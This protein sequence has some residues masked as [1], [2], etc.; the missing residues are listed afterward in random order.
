[1]LKTPSI[2]PK[3]RQHVA[4]P[5]HQV[6]VVSRVASERNRNADSYP[7]DDY[8]LVFSFDSVGGKT[9]E[10]DNRGLV[11]A[12]AIAISRV[13]ISEPERSRLC[14]PTIPIQQDYTSNMKAY[15]L[16]TAF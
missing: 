2:K 14:T 9:G 10:Q 3:V 8:G 5:S 6:T 7:S 4:A 16:C 11:D 1:M 12:L 15:N 13:R